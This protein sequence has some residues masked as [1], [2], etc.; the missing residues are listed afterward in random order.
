MDLQPSLTTRYAA[1]SGVRLNASEGTD[2]LSPSILPRLEG[3][4]AVVLIDAPMGVACCA[5]AAEDAEAQELVEPPAGAGARL[6]RVHVFTG[7]HGDHRAQRLPLGRDKDI[8]KALG[9]WKYQSES[10]TFKKSSSQALAPCGRRLKGPSHN[11]SPLKVS[12][13]KVYWIL[14]RATPR[15]GGKRLSERQ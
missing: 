7:D 3:S 12:I 13:P 15:R 5:D 8:R 14:G 6:H 2:W 9:D 4:V 1:S 10:I 11:Q